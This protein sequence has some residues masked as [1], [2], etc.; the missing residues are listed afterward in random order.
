MAEALRE[1]VEVG[2]TNRAVLISRT[3]A[4][5]PIDDSAAPIRDIAGNITGVV[6]TFRD[7]SER[8]RAQQALQESEER[9]RLLVE[10]VQDYAIFML[11]PAG[12]LTSWN[13]G[14]E[15]LL[16]YRP[17]DI[18]GAHLARFSTAPDVRRGKPDQNL[19]LAK[20]KGRAEDEGWRVRKDGSRSQA[21]VIITALR[22]D[23]G[24]LVGFAQVTRDITGL[25]QAEKQLT[26]SR[27]QLR[28]LAAY[29]QSVREEERTRIARQV[30]DE[31]GQALTGLKMDL[32]RLEKQFAETGHL[33][34]LRSLRQKTRGMP[35]VVDQIISAVR[36]I[37]TEL[38]PAVLDDLGLEAAIE[39]QIH[40][41]QKRTGIRCE[42]VSNLQD[43]RLGQDRATAAFR[44]FQETLTN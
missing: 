28:L 31:L 25:K 39:W 29:L 4:E 10:G 37:A 30:H 6:L 38:R 5:T 1:G 18:L 19:E 16:G 3:G 22:D 42:F 34:S 43:I 14:S 2:L 7:V 17:D 35:E 33:P 12:H 21:N 15:R 13:A 32:S 26:D 20:L 27:E 24:R 41:F 9:F 44:I 36:K 40:D 23:Q 8:Q 11:D